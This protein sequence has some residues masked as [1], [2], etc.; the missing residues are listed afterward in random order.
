MEIIKYIVL[1]ESIEESSYYLDE[2][3]QALLSNVIFYFWKQMFRSPKFHHKLEENK[4]K[5]HFTK[6]LTKNNIKVKG[7]IDEYIKQ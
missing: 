1:I 2:Q 7:I 4:T 3:G 5:K 6:Y